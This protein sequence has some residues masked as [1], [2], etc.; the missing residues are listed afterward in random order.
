MPFIFMIHYEKNIVTCLQQQ[1]L[2]IGKQPANSIIMRNKKDKRTIKHPTS[3]S[4]IQPE[5][6]DL[7]AF[8]AVITDYHYYRSVMISC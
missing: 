4:L 1:F 6:I 2:F 5:K 3:A 8:T 7:E